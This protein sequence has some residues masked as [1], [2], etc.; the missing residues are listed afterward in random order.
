MGM[1]KM[2]TGILIIIGISIVLLGISVS[3][4]G[5]DRVTL[6]EISKNEILSTGTG[7]DLPEDTSMQEDLRK[8][9]QKE[10]ELKKIADDPDTLDE[11]RRQIHQDIDNMQDR[12]QYPFQTGVPCPLVKVIQEKY[13]MFKEHRSDLKADLWVTYSGPNNILHV[14]HVLKMGIYPD[15]FTLTEL[16]H[17]DKKI[18]EYLGNEMNIL[19]QPFLITPVGK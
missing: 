15:H 4:L 13:D 1:G 3:V 2:K 6:Q 10:K 5:S 17:Q 14:H 8:L 19:Y 9:E 12:L 7:F 16:E 18:R 11:E